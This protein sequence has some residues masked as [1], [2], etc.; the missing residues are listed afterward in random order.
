MHFSSSNKKNNNSNSKFNN[1][2]TN[3][4]DFEVDGFNEDNVL[5]A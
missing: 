4:E 3:F 1:S 2:V 5:N